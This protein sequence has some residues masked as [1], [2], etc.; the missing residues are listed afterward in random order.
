MEFKL[1]TDLSQLPQTVEFNV[2]ELKS[3]LT[4]KLAYYENLVVTEDAVRDAK[5]DKA[6]LN[7]LRTAIDTKRK[8]VKK[9][10]LAP[11]EEF[12]RQCQDILD[13]IDRP[14][15][16]IDQ[17]IKVFE[18]KELD[19]KYQ[20]IKSHYDYIMT[21]EEC[22]GLPIVLD[23][24]IN[25]K[26]QNKTAKIET[27]KTEITDRVAKIVEDVN[28]IRYAYGGTP[29]LTAALN[30]YYEV[31]DAGAA[32]L[33]ANQ[34]IDEQRKRE[35]QEEL[36]RKKE[37]VL[38]QMHQNAPQAPSAPEPQIT[39]PTPQNAIQN[40][41]DH[42][43]SVPAVEKRYTCKFKATGTIEQIR[44]ARD[45]MLSIGLEIESIKD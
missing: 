12:E 39:A 40:A 41:P 23:K 31:Y 21:S 43:E 11:Y 1:I 3:E 9:A 26:W 45:Y 13:M 42:S 4:E 34:L 25:P 38:A 17:Q 19:A 5:S 18:Q 8:E 29:H 6:K 24:I 27:L 20:E 28:G 37:Q 10:C 30:R 16:S 44:N 22:S 32:H 15:N 2:E 14:I 36:A 35:E 33:Y 7:K